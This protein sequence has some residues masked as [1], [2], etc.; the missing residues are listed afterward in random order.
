ML[1]VQSCKLS[2][3]ELYN[4]YQKMLWA[5]VWKVKNMYSVKNK[6]LLD[7]FFQEAYI[8]LSDAYENDKGHESASFTTFAYKI[9]YRRLARYAQRVLKRSKVENKDFEDMSMI[10]EKS[11]NPEELYIIKEEKEDMEN[12]LKNKKNMELPVSMLEKGHNVAELAEMGMNLI[13]ETIEKLKN[14]TDVLIIKLLIVDE[15]KR[16]E[17]CKELSISRGNLDYR[18]DKLFKK[19][20]CSFNILKGINS[21][22]QRFTAK[23]LKEEASD[24]A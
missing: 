3:E 24:E 10:A 14:I 4:K 12:Y 20:G 6:D 21:F 8:G 7:D 13:F 16:E 22:K 17:V 9:I 23:I 5:I 11:K 15:L 18:I 1:E 2:M 19:I